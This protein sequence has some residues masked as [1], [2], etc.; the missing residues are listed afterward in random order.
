MVIT[1]QHEHIPNP[2]DVKRCL[3]SL[4]SHLINAPCSEARPYIIASDPDFSAPACTN[5][6][7]PR[8]EF[9]ELRRCTHLFKAAIN[10]YGRRN[11]LDDHLRLMLFSYLN[12]IEAD[13]PAALILN[14]LR[15]VSSPRQ[16]PTWKFDETK[17]SEKHTCEYPYEKFPLLSKLA[18]EYG[19]ALERILSLLYKSYLRNAVAHSHFRVQQGGKLLFLTKDY[20]PISRKKN[21]S[22]LTDTRSTTYTFEAVKRIWQ[23]TIHYWECADT[24]YRHFE[25][26]DRTN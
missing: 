19:P 24:V 11:E 17:K 10:V 23:S 5:G 12:I 9:I 7:Y 2:D 8:Q 6:W 15:Y 16:K 14:A 1:E 3:D 25:M 22:E 21:K 26:L 20:S 4:F 13:Y 18:K